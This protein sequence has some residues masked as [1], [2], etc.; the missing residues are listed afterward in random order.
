[1]NLRRDFLRG[2]ALALAAGAACFGLARFVFG[3][4]YYQSPLL[5]AS[6][7]AMLLLAWLLHLRADGFLPKAK[8]P[9]A[10]RK[11]TPYAAFH[12]EVIPREGGPQPW[13]GRDVMRALLWAAG[14]LALV[15]IALYH[16]AG[17]GS[18]Y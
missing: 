16:L 2:T 5:A 13:D 17:I 8:P 4:L 18:R 11:A 10:P 12:E 15:S 6:L 7:A 9:D 3:R 1:M 14:E